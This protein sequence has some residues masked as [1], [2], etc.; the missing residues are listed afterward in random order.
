M[1]WIITAKKIVESKPSATFPQDLIVKAVFL[2]SLCYKSKQT[3]F[4]MGRMKPSLTLY[5][6][7]ATRNAKINSCYLK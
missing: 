5:M 1:T 7:N 4:A 3:I 2:S 6:A